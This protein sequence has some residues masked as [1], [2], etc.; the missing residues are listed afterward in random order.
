V[1]VRA[2]VLIICV[3]WAAFMEEI[4]AIRRSSTN[5][6]FLLERLISFYTL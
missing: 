6:P 4:R 5:G 1:E 3:V 2:Q